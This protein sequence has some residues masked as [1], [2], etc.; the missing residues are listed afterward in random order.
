MS[1]DG[2]DIEIYEM[3]RGR[4]CNYSLVPHTFVYHNNLENLRKKNF[5]A[6]NNQSKYIKL[7]EIDESYN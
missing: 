2:N 6:Y 1:T 3:D 5:F 7:D 4:I